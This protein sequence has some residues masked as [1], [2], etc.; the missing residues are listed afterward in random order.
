[1]LNMLKFS[2]DVVHFYIPQCY[3]DVIDFSRNT[4]IQSI[5][6]ATGISYY[7]LTTYLFI[8]KNQDN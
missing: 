3:N 8:T 2:R 6:T 5:G 7:R 1:M 4:L